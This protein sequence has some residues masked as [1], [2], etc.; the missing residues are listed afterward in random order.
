MK[1]TGNTIFITGGTSGL[2]LGLA[3]RWQ[4][5]GNTVIISGRRKD[6]LDRIATEHPGIST[7]VLDVDDPASIRAAFDE[8]TAKNPDL[9]AV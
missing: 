7:V 5:L 6:L 2:G 4:E 9:N 8:V 3:L 1:T